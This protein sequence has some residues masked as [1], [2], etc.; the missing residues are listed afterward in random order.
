[1]DA[2]TLDNG[3]T[4]V[5]DW[6]KET[7]M[8]RMAADMSKLSKTIEDENLK[9]I[10]AI[11]SG[12][13]SNND[14]NKASN[15]A[16]S[17]AQQENTKEVQKVTKEYG[18]MRGLFVDFGSAVG[19]AVQGIVTGIGAVTGAVAALAGDVML[20]YTGSL[21]R[22]T[23]VGLNQADEFVQTNFELRTFGLSLADAT[24]FT[25]STASAFQALGGET[26]TKMLDTFD[27]LNS[28]GADFGLRLEDNIEVFRDELR[29]ATRMGNIGKLT[30]K[31]QQALVKQTSEL[32]ETQIQFSGA[33]GES[34]EVIRMFAI[35][36]LENATDF[37]ARLL[38]TSEATRQEMLKGAQEFV[39]VLRA[40]GGELGGELAAAAIEAASFGAIGFSESAK[41]FITVLPTLSGS[42]NNLINNFNNGL[43]DGKEAALLFTEQ[44][45]NLSEGEKQRIFAIAR[46]GDQQALQMAKGIM[47]FEKA[48]KKIADMGEDFEK[49]D[50]VGFQRMVNLISGSGSQLM[51]SIVAV[52]DKFIMSF[53]VGID[54]DKFTNAFA[55]LR[56]SLINLAETFFDID[57]KQSNLGTL[58][59]EKLPLAIDYVT[60]K[61]TQF[62]T[63]L[64]K[65]LENNEDAG[66]LET[67][68]KAILPIF[69]RIGLMLETEFK[70]MM[71][72]LFARMNP[73][74][75]RSEEGI[76]KVKDRKRE[77]LELRNVQRKNNEISEK[78]YDETIG[79][80][81]TGRGA[82]FP[83]TADLK[84][85]ARDGKAGYLGDV[86]TPNVGNM[87]FVSGANQ[88]VYS[89]GSTKLLQSE[90]E[91]LNRFLNNETKFGENF[92]LRKR[93][94]DEIGIGGL[95]QGGQR[96]AFRSSFDTDGVE[97]LSKEELKN[98][99]ETLILLTR[100]QTKVVEEGNQ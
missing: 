32:L 65:F 70:V 54:Y 59:G 67:F 95:G 84:I 82:S 13:G 12:K 73:L 46:T 47:Q 35:N 62:N 19:G 72:G 14:A 25:L 80:R 40:T 87:R 15:N 96:D 52:K 64:S 5:P 51:E 9:L 69:E 24:N 17:K 86:N 76:Q 50:P 37:Q 36:T 53:L 42:F 11:T 58:F 30:E 23:D 75:D 43:I 29:F 79:K 99:F 33:L 45:G 60:V 71:A 66:Y 28:A 4:V 100:K 49:L 26:I 90:Q 74:G 85:S 63:A 18:N 39:S 88:E 61:I 7:T 21:N 6:A 55:S 94:F 38:L 92:A 31:Q 89:L 68:K 77:E 81:G 97:G 56:E 48:A 91:K 10:R 16:N 41:R 78:I 22:L 2:I 1:M 93:A 34:V 20:R 57:G 8:K 44:L 83:S 3:Q 27:T 98:Y